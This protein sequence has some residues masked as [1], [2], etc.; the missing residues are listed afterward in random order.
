[1][2]EMKHPASGNKI[3][4]FQKKM[5]QGSFISDFYQIK[6]WDYDFDL[7]IPRNKTDID[8]FRQAYN[9]CFSIVIVNKGNFFID[10]ASNSY[11]MCSGHIAVEKPNHEYRFRPASGQCFVL[12]FSDQFY[13]HL[14]DDLNLKNAFFFS[15]ENI[16]LLVLKA[17]AEIEY[18][19][20]QI[21]KRIGEA[22]K[23]E[24]D[25]L[26]IEL[27]NRV[28]EMITNKIIIDE[29]VEP[30]SPGHLKIVEAAKAYLNENLSSDISLYEIS[31]YSCASAFHFAR[32]FKRITSYSPH[33]Y[34]L[35]I[36]LKQGEMMLKNSLAPIS[37]ISY[38]SGFSSVGYF[39][40]AFRQKYNLTPSEYRNMNRK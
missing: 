28:V 9:N 33:Q 12:H 6:F 31:R 19:H 23:L 11:D 8:C 18:I 7:A 10:L 3:G 27:L 5:S 4:P 30:P 24:M 20:F 38:S 37:D 35:G 14:I 32:I 22:G 17:L 2:M 36:R 25:N 1:M 40:T 21:V 15:N 16:L 26:V 34:L 13:R 39:A 29:Q